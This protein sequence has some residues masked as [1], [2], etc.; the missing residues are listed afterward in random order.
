MN[1]ILATNEELDGLLSD[2]YSIENTIN[3]LN[4]YMDEIITVRK[5]LKINY[6]HGGS[7]ILNKFLD[8]L[9]Y[10]Y[11]GEDFSPLNNTN[12]YYVRK[13]GKA[14]ATAISKVWDM[15]K[16]VLDKLGRIVTFFTDKSKRFYTSLND[17]KKYSKLSN[18][19]YQKIKLIEIR[20]YSYTELINNFNS[21]DNFSF[22][23]FNKLITDLSNKEDQEEITDLDY[24]NAFLIPYI[25]IINKLGYVFENEDILSNKQIKLSE[26]SLERLGFNVDTI[27]NIFKVAQKTVLSFNYIRNQYVLFDKNTSN[28][29]KNLIQNDEDEARYEKVT[30][31]QTVILFSEKIISIILKELTISTKQVINL[32]SKI[33]KELK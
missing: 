9:H 30:A 32:F 5:V 19:E 26:E 20:M 7:S 12:A 21:I 29:I 15:I 24:M 18:N 6:E 27:H 10:D 11:N 13:G 23:N 3:Q 16:W 33:E 8:H 25:D 2:I 28:I 17:Y 14:L 22:D 4:R 31:M 1:D